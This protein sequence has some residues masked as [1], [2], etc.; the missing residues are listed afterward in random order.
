MLWDTMI[1]FF[2][3][4]FNYPG[5][6]WDYM[7]AG[8]ALAI[9]F[10]GIWLLCFQ[11]MVKKKPGLWAVAITSAFITLLAMT[12]VQIPLQYYI[13]KG[14]V[15]AWS[16][17][18]ISDWLLLVGIPSILVSG[19]VQEGA[20]MVPIVFWW[21]Q[22]DK[23]ITPKEGLIIGA[24]AGAG[25]GVFEAVW[26]HNQVFMYGW[27]W[28]AIGID[29]IGALL[30]F[31]ERLWA[32]ALHIG[33]AA[34]A[35]YG[36]AKGKG[37]QFYLLASVLHSVVNYPILLVQKGVL[38]TNQV[39]ICLAVEAGLIMLAVLWLRWR[40]D[41]EIPATP[42]VPIEPPKPDISSGTGV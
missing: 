22:S 11:P 3:S 13:G 33:A 18:T 31:W 40:K 2:K 20:K 42:M 30:P 36:L 23:K 9:V 21:L 25:I 15:A 38:T 19:L 39:E 17:N 7:L 28:D 34:V 12:F 6:T 35:G 14:I 41:K 8:I 5:V 16:T 32:I 29:W 10:G 27:T 24:M 26:V 1:G 4:W 37:W